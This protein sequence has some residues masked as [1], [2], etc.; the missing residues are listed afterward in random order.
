LVFV[1]DPLIS[2]ERYEIILSHNLFGKFIVKALCY[3]IIS[4]LIED[5][6]ALDV[7]NPTKKE[8]NQEK[9]IENKLENIPLDVIGVS[10]E[11]ASELS[12]LSFNM[13]HVIRDIERKVQH[14][15]SDY[16][17]KSQ[18]FCELEG[19]GP[20]ASSKLSEVGIINVFDLAK[21]DALEVAK[22]LG[23]DKWENKEGIRRAD[24]LISQAKKIVKSAKTNKPVYKC[25]DK[26]VKT[27]TKILPYGIWKLCDKHA[28][29]YV[30]ADIH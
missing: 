4:H 30:F 6:K 11:F 5:K 26:N 29:K 27:V 22:I 16:Y 24:N 23:M 3:D 7:K 10:K 9:E 12:N 1:L 21:R 28:R 18:R 15:E 2:Q 17:P 20:V 8:K 25:E 13:G 14:L 19:V